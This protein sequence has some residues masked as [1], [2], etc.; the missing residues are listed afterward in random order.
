M[1]IDVPA[2]RIKVGCRLEI[3]SFH[4]RYWATR[5]RASAV[6]IPRLRRRIVGPAIERVLKAIYSKTPVFSAGA[7]VGRRK[8]GR[9]VALEM[10]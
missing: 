5:R 9:S 3:K 7:A 1:G 6:Q 8:S 2:R 10:F 4:Y